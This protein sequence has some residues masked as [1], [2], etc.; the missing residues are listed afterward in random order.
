MRGF[1]ILRTPEFRHHSSTGDCFMSVIAHE[2]P[3]TGASL[4]GIIG[5]LSNGGAFVR[6][7][8]V[9]RRYFYSKMAGPLILE[10]YLLVSPLAKDLEIYGVKIVE[11]R[12]GAAASAPGLTVSSQRVF[13]LIDLLSKGIVTPISLADIV[14]DWL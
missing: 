7:K 1:R 2:H 5:V 8:L 12:S 9:V 10:Y 6:E 14:E 4:S 3:H 11:Q 13:H